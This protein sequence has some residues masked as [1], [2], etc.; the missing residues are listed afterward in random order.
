MDEQQI[1]LNPANTALACGECGREFESEWESTKRIV[2]LQAYNTRLKQNEARLRVEREEWREQAHR[3]GV[4]RDRLI[5][6]L[7][8]LNEISRE[9][10][11]KVAKLRT[12]HREA[13][14]TV[15]EEAFTQA[16]ADQDKRC[17]ADWSKP[18][19]EVEDDTCTECGKVEDGW[20]HCGCHGCYTPIPWRDELV[21]TCPMCGAEFLRYHGRQV[22][23]RQACPVCKLCLTCHSYN[24]VT[25]YGC[26]SS[27]K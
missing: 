25:V 9:L 15:S 8:E 4:S 2:E 14:S 22:H 13:I 21:D 17:S 12:K 24:G 3:V 23:R 16:V 11:W 26:T 10:A 27:H 1:K 6:Y 18:L 19:H 7:K 20:G 5:A